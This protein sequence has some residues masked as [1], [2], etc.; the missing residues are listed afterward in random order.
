LHIVGRHLQFVITFFILERETQFLPHVTRTQLKASILV[1][2]IRL[3]HLKVWIRLFC[4]SIR[5]CLL[6][7]LKH[8]QQKIVFVNLG[9]KCIFIVAILHVVFNWLPRISPVFPV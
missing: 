6:L 7:Y 4:L 3:L 2:L 8:V 9:V 5:L 1:Y